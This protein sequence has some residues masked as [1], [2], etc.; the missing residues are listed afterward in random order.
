MVQALVVEGKSP[1][2]LS[3]PLLF[4]AY[5]L[6]PLLV[7]EARQI[8]RQ[9]VQSFQ[10]A[11]NANPDSPRLHEWL[12]KSAI[13]AH[14]FHTSTRAFDH[15]V[16][17]NPADAYA[18]WLLGLS[19]EYLGQESSLTFTGLDVQNPTEAAQKAVNVWVESG[20]TSS[21]YIALAQTAGQK[22]FF[23]ESLLWY[24]R[25]SQIMVQRDYREIQGEDYV[26]LDNFTTLVGWIPCAWCDNAPGQFQVKEGVI[27]MSYVNRVDIR[28]VYAWLM[29]PDV[30]IGDFEELLIRLRGQP[31][32]LVTIEVRE[33]IGTHRPYNYVPA[34]N[35]WETWPIS[36]Q[37][38]V[39]RSV[40]V[41]IAEPMTQTMPMQYVLWLDWIAIR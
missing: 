1:G 27:E 12:G 4:D 9:V 21:E 20:R 36:I 22:Q 38:D 19:Y 17:E 23:A 40:Y 14:D 16:A 6:K 15:L 3:D 32:T 2:Y 31:G 30:A 37:G 39:L 11:I 34:P 18:A 25:A 26:F 29:M 33:D 8:A 7:P 41:S 24:R 35:K 5:M 13:L 10:R 28:D